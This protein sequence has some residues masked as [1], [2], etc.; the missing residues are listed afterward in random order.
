MYF[1]PYD[2]GVFGTPGA[3][4]AA[5]DGEVAGQPDAVGPEGGAANANDQP[6][7]AEEELPAPEKLTAWLRAIVSRDGLEALMRALMQAVPRENFMEV[8]ERLCNEQWGD[9]PLV[10]HGLGR[11]VG[12]Y[13]SRCAAH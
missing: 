11:E 1:M 9:E 12:C 6:R 2:P 8:T 7:P 3:H 10:S 5:F 4:D 13:N